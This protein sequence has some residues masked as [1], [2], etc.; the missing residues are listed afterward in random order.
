VENGRPWRL[1]IL[2]PGLIFVAFMCDSAGRLVRLESITFRADEALSQFRSNWR[3]EP[4]EASRC[5]R[6][7]SSTGELA[8]ISN[9][10]EYRVF[11]NQVFT[12]DEL[13]FRNAISPRAVPPEVLMVGTSFTVGSGNSDTQTLPV[14]LESRSGC[15]T[16]NAGSVV[17]LDLQFILELVRKL[18]MRNGLVIVECLERHVG[19]PIPLQKRISRWNWFPYR[20]R[21][22][23]IYL[24]AY[25]SLTISPLKVVLQRIYKSFQNDRVLPNVHKELVAVRHLRDGQAMLF[26]RVLEKPKPFDGIPQN[27]DAYVTMRNDLHAAGFDLAL[28]IVPDKLTVYRPLLKEPVLEGANS[29]AFLA[30][31]EQSARARGIPVV[32]LAPVLADRARRALENGQTLWWADDTHWNPQ[33]I[34][35]AAEAICDAL[36]LRDRC[37]RRQASPASAP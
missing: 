5:Y 33:G 9:E 30:D 17:G 20:D 32:N 2:I 14:R 19:E 22:L 16:Y 28:I 13:G 29:M 34:E 7:D 1:D 8:V 6:N 12:T 31:L 23:A 18:G 26:P 4:Y 27:V 10:S 21:L 15:R 3:P 11:R 37:G 36:G 25:N 24:A 35:V